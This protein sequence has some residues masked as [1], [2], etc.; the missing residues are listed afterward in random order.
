MCTAVYVWSDV[1][2]VNCDYV[3]GKAVLQLVATVESR[4]D[5]QCL[6]LASSVYLSN[7]THTGHTQRRPPHR[8]HPGRSSRALA[9]RPSPPL[10]AR[11]CHAH[12][13]CLPLPLT[14]QRPLYT[15]QYGR[16][17][18]SIIHTHASH[19]TALTFGSSRQTVSIRYHT[20]AAPCPPQTQTLARLVPPSP[21]AFAPQRP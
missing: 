6:A 5:R 1:T 19:V 14:P 17:G 16:I 7:H 9:S 13:H 2:C 21:P 20:H 11:P 8:H 15:L 18:Q 3:N 4:G 12:G 10:G